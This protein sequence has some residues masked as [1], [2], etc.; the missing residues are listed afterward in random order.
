MKTGPDEASF[1][2]PTRSVSAACAGAA[3]ASAA[4]SSVLRPILVRAAAV[5]AVSGLL[6]DVA[7]EAVAGERVRHGKEVLGVAAHRRHRLR[8]GAQRYLVGEPRQIG[9]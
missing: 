7:A 8:T 6:G 4:V 9:I 1:S 2:T 3:S 5:A